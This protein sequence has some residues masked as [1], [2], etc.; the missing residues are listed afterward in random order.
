M[1]K[2]K[3]AD[4]ETHRLRSSAISSA[5]FE[6]LSSQPDSS[7][8]FDDDSSFFPPPGVYARIGQ[9][10]MLFR[11]YFVHTINNAVHKLLY[12][13]VNFCYGKFSKLTSYIKLLPRAGL[14]HSPVRSL[15]VKA[16]A[17]LIKS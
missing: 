8:P 10:G 12:S 11:W 3:I 9:N 5:K 2:L 1:L 16:L 14:F 13:I 6:L 4:C 15:K 7:Y 17:R